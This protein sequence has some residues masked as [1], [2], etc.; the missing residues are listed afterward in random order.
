MICPNTALFIILPAVCST[1]SF[2]SG[3]EMVV[4]PG[5]PPLTCSFANTASTIITAPSTISPKSSAPKLIRLPLTPKRF[6]MI[7][8]NNIANG[9]IDAT[10]SPAR[11]LPKKI[12]NT[13][14][15][16]KAPSSKLSRTVDM[17]LFTILERSR[18]G[19]MIT[20]SGKVF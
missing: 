20:P 14:K 6:I 12:T 11:R 18:K 15:T 19:S 10:N 1:R 3:F 4:N 16:I 13:N 5:K 9:I 8:A 17:A 7:T 2:I